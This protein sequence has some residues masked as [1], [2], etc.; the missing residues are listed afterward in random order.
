MTIDKECVT[1]TLPARIADDNGVTRQVTATICYETTEPWA[2]TLTFHTA[3]GRT[4]TTIGRELLAEGLAHMAGAQDAWIWPDGSGEAIGRA[5]FLCL[6]GPGGQTIYQL[7]LSDVD[8]FLHRCQSLVPAG[9]EGDHLDLDTE[10]AA[11]LNPG[12]PA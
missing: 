6:K 2:V 3:R 7:P 10:L 8:A 5:V 9:T 11:L 1:T 12:S 4:T